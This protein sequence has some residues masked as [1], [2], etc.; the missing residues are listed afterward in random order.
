MVEALKDLL[1]ASCF[2][3]MSHREDIHGFGRR[4]PRSVAERAVEGEV[5]A[6]I[7]APMTDRGQKRDASALEPSNERDYFAGFERVPGAPNLRDIYRKIKSG[8]KLPPTGNAK[9]ATDCCASLPSTLSDGAKKMFYE[10]LTR[11]QFQAPAAGISL[12][13]I[14]RDTGLEFLELQD[15]AS[16]L[17]R[18]G[19]ARQTGPVTY[20]PA[21]LL[22]S[23]FLDQPTSQPKCFN[24]TS[25]VGVSSASCFWLHSSFSNLSEEAQ[26]GQFSVFDTNRRRKIR[27]Y[28]LHITSTQ[29][30]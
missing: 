12:S 4:S 24:Q 19:R 5:D 14:A 2:I 17:E 6:N 26:K 20:L 1:E 11:P 9:F 29:H 3:V 13:H 30:L 7:V 28:C 23:R 16:E 22:R 27:D 25:I 8:F 21:G 15:Y 10:L 18:S